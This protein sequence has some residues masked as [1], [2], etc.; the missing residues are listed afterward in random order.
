[1]DTAEF[2]LPSFAKIN[3]NLRILGK[4]PDGYHQISTL[5]QTIS[6]HD[7]I[8]FASAENEEIVLNCDDP[9]LPTDRSNLILRAAEILQ[10]HGGA[11][12]GAQISLRKT[13]PTKAG[14]GG[15]S[16]NAAVALIGLVRLWQLD[17]STP[18]LLKVASDLGADVPFFLVGGCV[19]A[20]GIGTSLTLLPDAQP[21]YL[22]VITPKAEVS[23]AEAY[24]ALSASALTTIE[25]ET[26]LAVSHK[27]SFFDDSNLWDAAHGFVNDFEQVIFDMQPEIRRVKGVL[28]NV[29]AVGVL[30]AGS[31][32]SV[33]GI[34]EDKESQKKA[35]EMIQIEEGWRVFHCATISRKEYR[36]ALG[37]PGSLGA[38]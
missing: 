1:V 14:L 25:A 29:G 7:R 24:K 38:F 13:I 28:E 26:I 10:K 21:K 17:L 30:L 31:G 4:R 19:R 37:L 35:L 23:T 2:S 6:L 8:E 5:L 33:F 9:E 16:S 11:R 27:Q 15:G 18:E 12:Q 34:F 20:E 3:W 36:D 22:I 32:S